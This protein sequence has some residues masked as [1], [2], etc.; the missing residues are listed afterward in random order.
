MIVASPTLLFDTLKLWDKTT[1]KCR[2]QTILPFFIP[3]KCAAY[4]RKI[5]KYVLMYDLKFTLKHF[6]FDMTK[7]VQILFHTI[8]KG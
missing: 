2:A 4:C 1:F 3:I 5:N 8:T 6:I 7:V